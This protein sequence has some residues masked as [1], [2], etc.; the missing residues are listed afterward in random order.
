MAHLGASCV[1]ATL[2]IAL[3]QHTIWFASWYWPAMG[4][5]DMPRSRWGTL[6]RFG[7]ELAIYGFIGGVCAFFHSRMQTQQSWR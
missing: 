5:V 2:H 3:L 6:G 7:V 1:L 4:A